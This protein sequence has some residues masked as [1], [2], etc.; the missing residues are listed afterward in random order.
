META[1]A[2]RATKR[3]LKKR[4]TKSRGMLDHLNTREM[5][6]LEIVIQCT[7]ELIYFARIHLSLALGKRGLMHVRKVSSY[8]KCAK[9]TIQAES[10]A[11]IS[12][13]GLHRLIGDDILRTCIKPGFSRARFICLITL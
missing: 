1:C 10:F 4:L 11:L 3:N 2:K 8:I 13:N 7:D 9:N 12:L 5:V 6:I